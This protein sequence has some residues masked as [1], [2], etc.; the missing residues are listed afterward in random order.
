MMADLAIVRQ[1]PGLLEGTEIAMSYQSKTLPLVSVIVTNFNYEHFVL[2]CLYSILSQTYP[3]IECIVTDNASTDGSADAIARFEADTRSQW[4]GERSLKLMMNAENLHLI[5]SCHAGYLASR[6]DF[7]VFVDA[8]DVLLP[9]CVEAHVTAHLMLRI[10][11]GISSVDM[12]QR[13]ETGIVS[14]TGSSF[15]NYVLSGRGRAKTFARDLSGEE[16]ALIFGPAWGPAVREEQLH[17]VDPETSSE[18]VW[19]P[20]SAL[21]VRRTALSY[22]FAY[23]PNLRASVDAYLLRGIGSLTGSL[24]IDA[25]LAL[26]R[27][28]GGNIF[29]KAPQLASF[30]SH[31]PVQLEA[32]D[33]DVANAVIECYVRNC[34]QLE[35]A[36]EYSGYFIKAVNII[37]R[38]GMRP[39]LSRRPAFMREFIESNRQNLTAAFGARTIEEWEGWYPRPGRTRARLLRLFQRIRLVPGEVLRAVGGR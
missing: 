32:D 17:L 15:S 37:A 3:R 19:S 35:R 29:A 24:L 39:L 36:L 8:D 38:S 14:T 21:C 27:Y 5:G 18:W 25:P 10:P 26:Y 16:G 2:E 7:L 20:T 1:C 31:D 9:R 30:R 33:F 28:H 12:M 22:M 34:A 4:T 13:S 11:V 23:K 6:G